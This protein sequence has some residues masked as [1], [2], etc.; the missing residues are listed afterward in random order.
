[1]LWALAQAAGLIADVR[2]A[3]T[4]I[5]ERKVCKHVFRLR[6]PVSKSTLD[7][8]IA[9]KKNLT[10]RYSSSSLRTPRLE[11]PKSMYAI[12]WWL[13]YAEKTCER[14]PDS[15]VLVTPRRHMVR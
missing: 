2:F 14:L 5:G 15:A 3:C 12:C 10:N 13:N 7:R 11:T 1:M 4:Q 6:Y 8:A 9:A